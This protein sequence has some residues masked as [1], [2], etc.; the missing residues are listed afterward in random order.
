MRGTVAGLASPH[1]LIRALPGLY[2]GQGFARRFCAALDEVRAPV[3]STL[4][5]LAAYLDMHTVPDDMLPWLAAWSGM[6][7]DQRQPPERQRVLLRQAA[8]LHGS[9]GT[10][11]GIKLGVEA[12]SGLACVVAES[13]GTA[14]SQDAHADLPGE[15]D[16]RLTVQVVAPAGRVVDSEALEA[17]VEALKPAHVGHRI[18][19]VTE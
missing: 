14:W 2:Q 5:N 12:M 7:L 16:P 19:V 17:I 9:Q 6:V 13:G 1:P 18:D 11:R 3:E 4:D 8:A 10:A 15:P